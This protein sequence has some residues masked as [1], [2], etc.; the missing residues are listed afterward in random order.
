MRANRK[1]RRILYFWIESSEKGESPF[2]PRRRASPARN[3]IILPQIL[4][5]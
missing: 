4:L 1:P 2:S 5:A 3:F